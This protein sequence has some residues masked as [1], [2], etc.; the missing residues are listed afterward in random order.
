M[1]RRYAKLRTGRR[2]VKMRQR[3]AALP[4]RILRMRRK[5]LLSCNEKCSCENGNYQ[6]DA[7]AGTKSKFS[8]QMH[9]IDGFSHTSS[10]LC[11]RVFNNFKGHWNH[12]SFPREECSHFSLCTF[13]LDNGFHELPFSRL[14]STRTFNTFAGIEEIVSSHIIGTLSFRPISHAVASSNFNESKCEPNV[15]NCESR[16]QFG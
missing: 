2:R 7:F 9:C 3:R 8:L 13:S 12:E 10:V 11:A 15:T 4:V 14:T 1:L 5:Y 6:I 16:Y